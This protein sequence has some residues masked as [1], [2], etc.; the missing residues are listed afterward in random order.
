MFPN[1][2]LVSHSFVQ[3]PSRWRGWKDERLSKQA[4]EELTA[5]LPDR[6]AKEEE[7]L[8]NGPNTGIN[9]DQYT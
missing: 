5:L 3:G 1:Y 2:L 7:E 8:F 9:F 4:G 6:D